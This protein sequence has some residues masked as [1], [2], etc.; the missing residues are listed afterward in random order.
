MK[1]KPRTG[2]GLACSHAAGQALFEIRLETLIARAL[3]KQTR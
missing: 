1:N 3:L 2:S